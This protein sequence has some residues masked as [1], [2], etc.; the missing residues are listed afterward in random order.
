MTLNVIQRNMIEEFMCPGCMLGSG[1]DGCS[2]FEP[3]SAGEGGFDPS[4]VNVAEFYEDID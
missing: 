2:K 3:S 1:I 4:A